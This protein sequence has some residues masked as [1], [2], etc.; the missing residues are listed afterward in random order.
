MKKVILTVS[1]ILLVLTS[2]DK[3]DDNFL[4]EKTQESLQG[5]YNQYDSVMDYKN[6]LELSLADALSQ[7]TS[8]TIEND[9]LN[10]L[11]SELEAMNAAFVIALNDAYTLNA[12]LTSDLSASQ[13]DLAE[14]DKLL[15]EALV[16]AGALQSELEDAYAEISDLNLSL[17]SSQSSNDTLRAKIATLKNRI[18]TKNAK[19]SRLKTRIANLKARN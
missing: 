11:V 19:I 8:L 12:K 15:S 9:S 18:S 3:Q 10:V 1:T 4:L 13:S 7:I 2:C 6:E 5:M 17:S 16:L 14:S